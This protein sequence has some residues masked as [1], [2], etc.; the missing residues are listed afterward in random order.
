VLR[1]GTD[2]PSFAPRR[3]IPRARRTRS[4]TWPRARRAVALVV[5]LAAGTVIVPGTFVVAG[6]GRPSPT[7]SP[8][9]SL[10]LAV[11][12]QTTTSRQTPSTLPTPRPNP[13]VLSPFVAA[14]SAILVELDGGRVLFSKRPYH[15]MPIASLVKVM[16]ALIVLKHATMAETVTVSSRAAFTPPVDMGLHP[17]QRISVEA[18]LYG[19]LLRSGNDAAVALGE[20]ISGSVPAFLELMNRE[21][22]SLGL[23]HTW[24]ASPNGL[25][26]RGFS[27][28]KDLA[29][30]TRVALSIPTFAR[31]VNT[32][33]F[34]LRE[35]AGRV[36]VLWNINL[37]RGQYFGAMGVKT[38]FTTRAGQCLIAAARRGGRT[39]IAV[40]LGESAATHW[41]DAFGDA[42][43]L[44]DYGF[45]SRVMPA[46]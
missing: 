23:R 22:R 3:A 2:R 4:G 46:A 21:G 11:P 13:S 25:D 6:E 8:S 43:R 45:E 24:F 20:H 12:L 44:L 9:V 15:S 18:L 29:T 35:R 16:T 5:V 41:Q 7:S 37:F 27:T 19:L 26:D 10:P 1:P 14:P 17:G 31:I 33:R 28:A 39:L 34:V 40:V 36:R 30:L 42:A 32:D 38:G